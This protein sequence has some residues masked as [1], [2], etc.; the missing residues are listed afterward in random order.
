MFGIDIPI[1]TP[2]I[3]VHSVTPAEL[4]PMY[5]ALDFYGADSSITQQE[6]LREWMRSRFYQID[7]VRRLYTDETDLEPICL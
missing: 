3:V 6:T 4:T 1:P 7:Q 2:W 5:F